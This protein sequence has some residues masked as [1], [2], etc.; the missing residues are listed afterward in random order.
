MRLT[1]LFR[2][3]VFTLLSLFCTSALSQAQYRADL[4]KL[5]VVGDSLS[6]GEQNFSL[7]DTQQVNGYASVIARQ[8]NVPLTLPLIPFPG[9]P[10]VLQLTSL[11][12]L[13][14]APAPNPSPN[15]LPNP[16][17][18]NP[19][20]QPTNLAT[21]GVS[22][23]QALTLAPSSTIANP[24]EGWVDLVL[25]FPNP[26]DPACGN[27][28]PA[29]TQIQQA[30]ALQPTAI[31]EYLGNDDALLPALIGQLST[32]TPLSTFASSYDAALD[33][34]KQTH[35]SIITATI[36]DVSKVP[37]F[38]SVPTL[39]KQV[40]LPPS[41]VAAKLGIGVGDLLLPTASPKALSILSNQ[42]EG[43]L[44]AVCPAPPLS[45]PVATVPCVL[46]A[47]DV[48]Y[49][50]GTID[51]YNVIIFAES[52]AHGAAVVDIHALVDGLAQNGYKA[53]GKHLTTQFL[54][55]I[56]SLD[57]IHPTNTGYAIIANAFIQVMNSSWGT[58]IR[59]ANVDEI[60]AH[61]P[62][63]PPVHVTPTTSH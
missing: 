14:I 57:G 47:S 50:Q 44:P 37:Y 48:A 34:L 63:V 10:N 5:V 15:S 45:L 33:A 18:D 40:N 30:V 58:N 16:H 1:S 11:N 36:P 49:L 46:T 52:F 38:T 3:G 62:L 43:P 7:L 19:C 22:L 42:S 32:L 39:A 13:T 23:E 12:P 55:G 56:V 29:L 25:G 21:P 20:T 27:S 2:Y 24:L 28:G 59:P 26:L 41:V 4:S 53:D 31:I 17:R 54:G 51:A 9:A 61:D 6:A 35:A 60:A 8:A